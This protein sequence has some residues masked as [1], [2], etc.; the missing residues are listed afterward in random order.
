MNG[1]RKLILLTVLCL[2]APLSAEEG[3]EKLAA[4]VDT[5]VAAYGGDA[6]TGL[7]N[8]EI[9]ESYVSPN[10]G[11]SWH[12][13][14]V[15]IGRVNFRLMHDLEGGNHYAESWFNGRTGQFP[16]LVIVNGDGAWTINLLS[17]RY[18]EAASADPYVNAGGIMR[19]TDTLLALELH[20]SRDEAEYLGDAFWMNRDHQMVKIPFPQSPDLTLYVDNETGLITRMTRENPQLGLLDYVF[21]DHAQVD[22]IYTARSVNFSVAG[23]PN[24]MGTGRELRFNRSLSPATFLIPAGLDREGERIDASEMVVN[25]LSGNVYHIGQNAGFSIFVDTGSEVIGCGGY[26]GLTQRLE[27]FREETGNFRPLRYQVVTHHHQD[28][29]GGI[30]EA[31]TLGATLVTVDHTVPVIREN[32]QLSPGDGRFLAVNE[33]MT[34]GDGKGQVELYDVSTNHSASNLLFYVPSTRTLFIADHFGGPFAEGVPTANS[35]TVSMA[36]A[37]K[38]L[39]L[40]FNRVVTAHNARVYSGRD[41]NASVKAY[42]DYDCPDDRPLCSR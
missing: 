28:H 17:G 42:R 23:D 14:L 18:G 5:V 22:G 37:L 30:D 9:V 19:T 40:D 4:L 25:R 10:T 41:F 2:S 20:K 21:N 6:L 15:D 32:S 38:P 24:L 36:E 39:D 34:L 11:Q 27:K 7:R 1:I 3:D 13:D 8:Y 35:N 29:L 26:P 33:R 31:L 12:P 16:N